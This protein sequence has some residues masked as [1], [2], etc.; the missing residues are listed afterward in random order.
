M[1]RY[2]D[3]VVFSAFENFQFNC[4]G[5]DSYRD[6]NTTNLFNDK[7]GEPFHTYTEL[8]KLS[9][10]LVCCDVIEIQVRRPNIPQFN[11][12]CHAYHYINKR[13]SI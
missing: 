2:L 7:W 13:V 9:I 4:C 6:F 11:G 5:V 12:P 8:A 10:P 1:N 3:L